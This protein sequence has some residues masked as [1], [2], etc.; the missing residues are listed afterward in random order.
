MECLPDQDYKPELAKNFAYQSY[1]PNPNVQ[2]NNLNFMPNFQVKW[3]LK[4]NY[5]FR[6]LDFLP[7]NPLNENQP[8]Y[9]SYNGQEILYDLGNYFCD[10]LYRKS[11]NM[12][13]GF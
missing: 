11:K 1:V 4:C 12:K 10:L 13:N 7:G 5:P 9:K 6:E 8:I 2:F 3:L